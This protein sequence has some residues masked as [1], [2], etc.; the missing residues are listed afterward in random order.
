MRL[1]IV[2]DEF[3]IQSHKLVDSNIEFPQSSDFED[4][5]FTIPVV[6][7]WEDD[8]RA[9]AKFYPE[10]RRDSLEGVSDFYP[11]SFTV[12]VSCVVCKLAVETACYNVDEH[13]VCLLQKWEDC[14]LDE[15][16]FE[17]IDLP[18]DKGLY[19]R[20]REPYLLLKFEKTCLQCRSSNPS[21]ASSS[22]CS[23]SAP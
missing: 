21:T 19:D 6:S 2:G 15:E 17:E 23:V 9:R 16:Q 7:V 8:S 4:I 11:Y 10:W 13:E 14:P 12:R 20:N 18:V 3:G 5:L 22:C 1:Q